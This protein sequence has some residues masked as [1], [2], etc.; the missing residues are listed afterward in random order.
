P[1]AARSTLEVHP[2]PEPGSP[3]DRG[4]PVDHPRHDRGHVDRD[5][6]VRGAVPVPAPAPASTTG[7]TRVRDVATDSPEHHRLLPRPAPRRHPE[8]RASATVHHP[9]ARRFT[10]AP[11]GEAA[12]APAP[13]GAHPGAD[14]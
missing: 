12:R 8:S 10:A 2:R 3:D 6:T 4:D 9:R 1:G 11:L 5:A 14:P 13:P 7:A